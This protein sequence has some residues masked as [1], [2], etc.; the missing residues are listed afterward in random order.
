M[1]REYIIVLFSVFAL[2]FTFSQNTTAPFKKQLWRNF[3]LGWD[4]D[5]AD[6][7]K[8]SNFGF[9]TG[10]A[11]NF[12]LSPKAYWYV[13]GDLNWSKYTLYPDGQYAMGANKAYFRTFSLSVP[14]YVGYNVYQSSHK[15]FKVKLY[16]GPVFEGIFSGKLDG[17][18]Y[19]DY[20]SLQFGWTVGTGVRLFYLF[21][22][23]LA[24]RYYPTPLLYNGNLVRSS[25]NFTLGF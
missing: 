11:R 3:H 20:N 24:Y 7:Y 1:K 10:I 14:A 6:D 18:L 19:K 22:F 16:T 9:G 4:V 25:V 2:N 8:W 17:Y 15:A 23:N 12:E 5:R 13:G 21:G